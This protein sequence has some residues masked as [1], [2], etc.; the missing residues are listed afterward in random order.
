MSGRLSALGHPTRLA[1]F[2]L[3]MRRHPD[4]VPAGE[5]SQALGLKASTLS[6]CL[7]VLMRAGLVTR[8][9]SGTSL[10]YGVAM[11][12]LQDTLDH[13]LLDCCRGRPELCAPLTRSGGQRSLEPVV[14]PHG[15]AK[16][17]FVCTGNSARSIMAEAILRDEAGG[18]LQVRSAGT[19]PCE[20]ANAMAL[21]VLARHGHDIT[22]LS[23]SP[24]AP[25]QGPDAPRFD[26]VFTLCD[27]AANEDCPA[28]P[29][30]PIC[31]HWGMP[32]PAA[33]TG[34]DDAKRR[35]FGQ[36]HASLL[37]RIRAFASLPIALL[38]RPALQQAVDDIARTH[39]EVSS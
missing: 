32:D 25:L 17:L 20:S 11:S 15:I 26:F 30:A 10:R 23:P 22:A 35:A 16:V 3:L 1:I 37:A 2:R 38:D 36:A 21:A 13:L 5:L 39:P 34:T 7:A 31:A 29:G 14:A 27:R 4:C 12:G 19:S 33:V 18:R 8:Q 28:W 9:R 24:L 6:A